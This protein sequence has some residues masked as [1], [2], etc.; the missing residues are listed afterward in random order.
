MSEQTMLFDVGPR[1]ASPEQK[2]KQKRNWENAFQRWCD[3]QLEDDTT[4]LGKC[5]Y[6]FMCDWCDGE[7]GGRPCVR[8]LN[9]MCR[10][11]K[12]VIDY[13]NRDFNL[14]WAGFHRYE[15]VPADIMKRIKEGVATDDR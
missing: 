15:K 3:K 7:G 13:S 8:A 2:Q 9:A 11:L 4:S 14:A 1:S 5:G 12:I 10:E 6:G